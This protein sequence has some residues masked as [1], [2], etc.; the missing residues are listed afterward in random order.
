MEDVEMKISQLVD[1][2]LS[3]YDQIEVFG[4]LA[5]DQK[6][7]QIYSELLKLKKEVAKHHS[8]VRAD[9]FP[10]RINQPVQKHTKYNFYKIGFSFSSAAAV[11]LIMFLWW[12]QNENKKTAEQYSSLLEKYESIKTDKNQSLSKPVYKPAVSKALLLKKRRNRGAGLFQKKESIISN[13]SLI[14]NTTLERIKKYTEIPLAN[15]VVILKDDF[16][17]GQIV[18]N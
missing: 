13:N 5:K 2:E 8:E 17:G 1:N 7:R 3:D 11:I 10:L 9:L 14:A 15:S 12:G 4:L 6:A 18:S 16:I